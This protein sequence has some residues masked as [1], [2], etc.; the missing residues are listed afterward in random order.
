MKKI[1]PSDLR[2]E[3]QRL[4]DA[5]KMPTLDE[6]LEA[7]AFARQKYASKIKEARFEARLRGS[8]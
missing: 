4:I 7:V 8:V 1:T 2:A 6:L 3:A 5:G